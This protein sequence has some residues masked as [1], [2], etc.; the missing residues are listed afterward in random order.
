MSREFNGVKFREWQINNQ[1]K[2]LVRIGKIRKSLI[3]RKFT[4]KHKENL[5]RTKR[6]LYLEGKLKIKGGWNKGLTKENNES[7]K[8]L[9]ETQKKRKSYLSAIEW[10]KK[11][12]KNYHKT[13]HYS[14]K[15]GLLK[16]PNICLKCRTKEDLVVHHI[17][18]NVKNNNLENLEIMCRSCHFKYHL[19]RSKVKQ[20]KNSSERR[21]E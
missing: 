10:Q 1:E 18:G 19:R 5:S 17:D 4:K 20:N 8:K 13:Y 3:G 16:L 6:K 14:N 11:Y 12:R 15:I 7:M 2:E 9:S 21:V